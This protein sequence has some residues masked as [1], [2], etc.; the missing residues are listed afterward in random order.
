MV[1]EPVNARSEKGVWLTGAAMVGVQDELIV[2]THREVGLRGYCVDEEIGLSEGG[3]TVAM[4][5]ITGT[6]S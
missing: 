5:L 2:G 1:S 4:I 3:L 6:I